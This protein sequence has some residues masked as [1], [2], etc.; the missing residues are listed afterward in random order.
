MCVEIGQIPL[1]PFVLWKPRM[2][3]FITERDFSEAETTFPGIA[4]LY[5]ELANKPRTFLELVWAYLER[6]RSASDTG[7]ADIF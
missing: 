4:A 1:A 7:G 6:A 5:G 3:G 2:R